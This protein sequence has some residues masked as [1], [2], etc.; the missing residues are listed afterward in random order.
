MVL[1]GSGWFWMVLD[2]SADML[3][4]DGI[5]LFTVRRHGSCTALAIPTGR[6]PAGAHGRRR[7]RS[8]A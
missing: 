1:D 3:S 7:A 6:W 5:V 8:E 4:S 2:G